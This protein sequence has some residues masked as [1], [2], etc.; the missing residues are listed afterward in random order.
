MIP[1]K[2][3]I[4]IELENRSSDATENHE[5][6][7]HIQNHYWG[8]ELLRNVSLLEELQGHFPSILFVIHFSLTKTAIYII[9]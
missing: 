2:Q 6:N 1:A 7:H 4:R 9:K 5:T 3:Q 8:R